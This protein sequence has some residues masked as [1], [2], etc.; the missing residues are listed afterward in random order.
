MLTHEWLFPEGMLEPCRR[1]RQFEVCDGGP[2]LSHLLQRLVDNLSLE[3]VE[4]LFEHDDE[5]ILVSQP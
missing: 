1:V 4:S 3:T 5:V 2:E